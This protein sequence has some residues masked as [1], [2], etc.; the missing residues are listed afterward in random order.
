[1]FSAIV[2]IIVGLVIIAVRSEFGGRPKRG[3]HQD[4]YVQQI[5]LYLGILIIVIGSISFVRCFL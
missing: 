1:M 2:T 5:L 4:S 3:H